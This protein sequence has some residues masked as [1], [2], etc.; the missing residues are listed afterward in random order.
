ME[1]DK[2]L[3]QEI[4]QGNKQSFEKLFRNYYAPLCLFAH[5]FI[6]D[7]DD[8]EEVVQSFFLKIWEKR[9][10][11]DINTSAKSYLYSS[12]RN[13]SINYIKHQKIKQQYQSSVNHSI[14]SDSHSSIDFVEIDLI[15]KVNLCIASLPDRRRE[16]F[17]L[18]REHGMKY[19]EIADQLGISIKTVE[20]QMGHA[21]KELRLQLRD[22]QQLLI[23]FFICFKKTR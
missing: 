16:I 17:V 13:R 20:T 15:E 12:I 21:L 22:Y 1:N 10:K 14:G 11:I 19:R 6:N 7:R 3:F 5:R 18:S 4:K 2:Q 23:S 8:C 9:A